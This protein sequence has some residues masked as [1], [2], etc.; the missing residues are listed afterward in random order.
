MSMRHLTAII[1]IIK[2]S[3]HDLTAI[4]RNINDRGL[5]LIPSTISNI[6]DSVH[7]VYL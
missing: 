5:D 3:D 1:H 7:D 4:T 2:D 6:K